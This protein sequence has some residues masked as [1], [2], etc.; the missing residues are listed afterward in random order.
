MTKSV[1][2]KLKEHNGFR[3]REAH[4]ICS[5][6]FSSFDKFERIHSIYIRTQSPLIVMTKATVGPKISGMYS[7]VPPYLK[8]A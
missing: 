6:T 4:G 8:D 7:I 5:D 1:N 3:K 2:S